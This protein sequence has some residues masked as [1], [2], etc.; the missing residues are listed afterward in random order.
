M[1]PLACGLLVDT[2]MIK[3]AEASSIEPQLGSEMVISCF[4]CSLYLIRFRVREGMQSLSCA[5]CSLVT[6]VTISKEGDAWGI[7]T[8]RP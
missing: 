8:G 4:H 7:R 6:N 5:R 2:P 3:P 1:I